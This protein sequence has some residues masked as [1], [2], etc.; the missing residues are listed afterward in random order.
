ML[1]LVL[2]IGHSE[3]E[4]EYEYEHRFTE[5]EQNRWPKTWVKTRLPDFGAFSLRSEV[6]RNW[7]PLEF[8]FLLR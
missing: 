2:V 5:H 1:V 8:P 6:L 3:Y 4:Y 7:L